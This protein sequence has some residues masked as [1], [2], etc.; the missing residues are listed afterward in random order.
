VDD[1]PLTQPTSKQQMK[2]FQIVRKENY[3]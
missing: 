1:H 3:F 2:S